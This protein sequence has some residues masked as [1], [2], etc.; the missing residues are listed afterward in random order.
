MEAPVVLELEVTDVGAGGV[1]IGRHGDGRVVFIT[2]AIPGERVR[3]AVTGEGKGGRFLRAD[4]VDVVRASADRVQPPCAHAGVCGGCSWQHVRLSR[5]REL[6]AQVLNDALRRIGKLDLGEVG[7]IAPPG[8]GTRWRTRVRMTPTDE[9]RLG[10]RARRSHEIVPIDDC[11]I[12]AVPIP[13]QITQWP[14]ETYLGPDEFTAIGRSWRVHHAGFWQPH[15]AA[16]E[17]LADQVRARSALAPGE[18]ALDLYSG[19]GLFSAVLADQVGVTG[20]VEAVESNPAAVKN[21][22]ANL[23]DLAQVRHHRADVA[24]WLVGVDGPV[25]TVVVDPPR[26]GLGRA[27]VAE[28][29]RIRPRRVVMVS[30]D[31]ASFA[32][33]LSWFAQEGWEVHDV[34]GADLFPMTAHLEAVATLIS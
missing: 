21:A 34:V 15:V 8:D 25:E 13:T 22:K 4:V 33:D 30:C 9:G 24:D 18:R 17:L 3:V 19:V 5:Q 12:S 16:A 29:L 14:S 26:A 27:V 7:V 11:I 31:P 2:G 6:K 20:A 32:R 28:L 10:F 23:A 1:C